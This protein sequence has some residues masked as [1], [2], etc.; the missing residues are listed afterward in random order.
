MK[1]SFKTQQEAADYKAK[2]PTNMVI[3]RRDGYKNNWVLV[4]D[5]PTHVQVKQPHINEYSESAA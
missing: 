5:I 1:E 2:N 3:K 4:F